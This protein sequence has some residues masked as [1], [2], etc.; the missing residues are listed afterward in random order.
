MQSMFFTMAFGAW[1]GKAELV[2]ET[3]AMQ[4]TLAH[5]RAVTAYQ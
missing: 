3:L 2:Q 4:S 5:V 1:S